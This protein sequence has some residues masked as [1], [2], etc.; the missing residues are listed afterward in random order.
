MATAVI[1]D[2]APYRERFDRDNYL[3]FDAPFAP[4]F[5]TTV[6]ARAAAAQF[7]DDD[8]EYVGRRQIEAPQRVGGLLNLVLARQVLRDWIEQATGLAPCCAASGRLVQTIAGS[9]QSLEWHD[10]LNVAGRLLG[11]VINLSDT[12]FGGGA[13]ELRRKGEAQPLL[14]HHYTQPGAMMVF[15]VN[16][17][18][19]HRV[20]EVTAGGPRRVYA[21][22]FLSTQDHG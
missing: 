5:L 9:A 7:S 15:A 12:A 19:E 20:A 21:G 3:L 10:D 1:G 14:T 11:V 17:L 18:L 4:A 2:P 6:M 8:V 22:W 16:N 13:F